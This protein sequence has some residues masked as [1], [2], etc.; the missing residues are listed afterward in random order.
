[1][2]FDAIKVNDSVFDGSEYFEEAHRCDLYGQ[3]IAAA[4]LCRALLEAALANRVDSD[5]WIKDQMKPQSSYIHNMLLQA[6]LAGLID[7]N[8]YKAGIIVWQAGND[9]IHDLLK[10]HQFYAA[11]MP[12]II[13][14]TR[15]IL[16]DLM[17]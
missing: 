4:V 2:S 15:K 17:K 3:K 10:F 7:Q 9:A 6:K 13:D 12:E 11:K 8:R 5:Q 1:M 16:E 14:S